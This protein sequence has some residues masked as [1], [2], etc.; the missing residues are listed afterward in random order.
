V[1]LAFDEQV[2][3]MTNIYRKAWIETGKSLDDLPLVGVSR[4]IVVAETD[5]EAKALASR[6]Y[7]RWVRSFRKLWL[8]NGNKA[9]LT[10]LYPD[11]WEEL[12]RMR[13]GCAGSPAVVRRYAL[14]EAE[15]CGTNYLVSWFAFGDLDVEHVIRSVDLFSEQVMPAFA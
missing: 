5:K 2:K 6:A 11:I 8:D 9:P 7:T 15:R 10:D 12:E 3:T 14:E 4:H 13:N 1:T